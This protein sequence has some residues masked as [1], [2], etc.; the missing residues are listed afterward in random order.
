MDFLKLLLILL[1]YLF[2]LLRCSNF[3]M[4]FV[5]VTSFTLSRPSALLL[6]EL[7][8]PRIFCLFTT[9]NGIS[10]LFSSF[11]MK[12]AEDLSLLSYYL[13]HNRK[14]LFPS[15]F[16]DCCGLNFVVKALFLLA[17]HLKV[18]VN[19]RKFSHSLQTDFFLDQ[20]N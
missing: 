4:K 12:A 15:L 18:E 5:I 10:R 6:L 14:A 7:F 20:K 13:A 8:L 16:E 17:H 19:D 1:T 3:H 11:E 9:I 2:R